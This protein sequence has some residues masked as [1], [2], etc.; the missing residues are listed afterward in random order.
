LTVIGWL[1]LPCVLLV[2]TACDWI[3]VTRLGAYFSD[4]DYWPLSG[5]RQLGLAALLVALAYAWRLSG[6]NQPLLLLV[7]CILLFAVWGA[8]AVCDGD[9]QRRVGYQEPQ[10]CSD[11]DY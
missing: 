2:A 10:R 3:A 6:T 1:A 7:P 9:G 11:G 5:Q 4:F 8:G